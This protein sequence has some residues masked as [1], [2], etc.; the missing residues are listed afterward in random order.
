MRYLHS[1]VSL[2]LACGLAAS[3]CAWATT[4]KPKPR[5]HA[6]HSAKVKDRKAKAYHGHAP[7]GSK[8]A[9]GSVQQHKAEYKHAHPTAEHLRPTRTVPRTVDV[10]ETILPVPM[11]NGRLLMPRPLVGSLA[12]LER[13]NERDEA[14]GLTRIEDDAQLNAMRREGELVALPVGMTL[15]ANPEL[16]VNRRYTRPWTA[17]FL[18]DTARAHYA[19]FHR[20]LQVNSAVRTVAYQ[21]Y[22]MRVN[23]NAA[24]ADGDIASPHLT[25]AA[26]DIAKKGLSLSEIAWMRAY[27]LPLQTAG[28]IDVEEEFYQS[29]FHIT[30]YKVY[31]PMARPARRVRRSSAALLAA[32]VR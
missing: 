15:R 17:T 12:S 5:H 7:V 19:R 1:A 21:R 31:M 24:P 27:L 14:E 30:V 16:P 9:Q 23:G 22:L 2:V 3:P 32:G 29:C 18:T 25:G 10:A 26:I 4:N 11:R 6:K 20:P 13:Q 8:A 28:K